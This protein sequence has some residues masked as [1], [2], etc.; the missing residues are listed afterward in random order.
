MG[1]ET[2]VSAVEPPSYV[3]RFPLDVAKEALPIEGVGECVQREH[4]K[5]PTY[6]RE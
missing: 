1:V 2:E 4:A 5:L 3:L 6:M